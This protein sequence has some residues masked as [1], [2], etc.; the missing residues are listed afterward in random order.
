M[1][2]HRRLTDRCGVRTPRVYVRACRISFVSL[3]DASR[4]VGTRNGLTANNKNRERGGLG[5]RQLVRMH[6]LSLHAHHLRASKILTVVTVPFRPFRRFRR[7]QLQQVDVNRTEISSVSD[8]STIRKTS[9]YRKFRY[10]IPTQLIFNGFNGFDNQR[11][12]VDS[13][14]IRSP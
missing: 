9:I 10:D 4:I 12:S 11:A 7:F 3:W 5:R 14:P 1:L 13:D 8:T 6:A 2:T